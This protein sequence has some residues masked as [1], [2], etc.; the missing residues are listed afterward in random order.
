MTLTQ[1][2]DP[3]PLDP[4]PRLANEDRAMLLGRWAKYSDPRKAER[5]WEGVTNRWERHAINAVLDLEEA[6]NRLKA[7]YEALEV[8]R[9]YMDGRAL[10][11]QRFSPREALEAV[12][13]ALAKA[14]EN[15]NLKLMGMG[16]GA[17]PRER[18]RRLLLQRKQPKS[19][20]P[21]R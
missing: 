10:N 14:K 6:E 12:N 16:A 11:G 19:K 21:P 2:R 8:A 4:T 5:D 15:P 20:N 3:H 9:S 13:A 17:I 1:R 7:A 18:K